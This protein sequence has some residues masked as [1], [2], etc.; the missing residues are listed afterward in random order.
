MQESREHI[1][2]RMLKNAARAWG[3]TET[4]SES[5]FDPLVSMLLSACSI[6]LEKISG[7]I[8]GSRARVLERLVQ[9]L[10]PDAFTGAL[11]A[12]AIGCATPLEKVLEIAEDAQYYITRKTPAATDN[13][14]PVSRDIFFSPASSYRLNKATVRFMAA[15]RSLY[16]ISNGINKELMMQTESGKD[17]PAN[18]L[19]LGIDEPGT[20][21]K[22]TLFHFDLRNEAEKQLFYHQLPKA[23]WYWNEQV[24]P[25]APGYGN[26][27]ISG[28]QLDLETVLNREDDVSGKIKKQVNAFYKPYFITLLDPKNMAAGKDNSVLSAMIAETF[29][30]K[31]AAP[32]QQ[33]PLRWIC[34]DFPQTISSR[35]LQD[36]VCVMNCFPLIN[37][38]LHDLTYRLHE[39]VNIIPLQTEDLFLDLEDVSNDEGKILNTRSFRQKE[40]DAFGILLRNGGVGRFDERDAASV[41][42]YLVQLLRDESAAFSALGNDFMNAEMKQIQQIINKLEQ[43]LFS[44]HQ[45]REQIPYLMVRNQSKTALQNIFLRY[46]STRGSEANHIKAGNALH[47]Y[48]GSSIENNQ[49]LL[50]TTTVGGRNKLSTTDSVLAYKSALLSKDR[51]ITTEDIKA[52]CHYQL[53]AR[54]KRI[55]VEKGIMIHPDQQQG[56]L[57]TIDVRICVARKDFE[58]MQEKGEVNFWVDN[59]RLLLEEKSVALLPYRVF[60]EQ[61]A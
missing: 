26:R 34:I 54:V 29:T 15:G 24:I 40:E 41:V 14:E 28:E 13:E 37:R 43:R 33:Q 11:P 36:V 32:L 12:H 58:D 16:K 25:H 4:E 21:L 9:L 20:S 59:L 49:V 1:K 48:K 10:S 8:Q 44:R 6:E 19:W 35:L 42:D 47:L 50:V 38:R 55:D 2:T 18:T 46:W 51:L 22:N 30:G 7:E 45:S 39:M 60:I 56:F 23:T 27:N 31:L 3:Y 53:G 61:A 5:N 17:L 52:F 57:K